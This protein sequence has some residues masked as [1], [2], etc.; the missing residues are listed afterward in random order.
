MEK[1]FLHFS[2]NLSFTAALEVTEEF[3]IAD[4]G[5]LSSLGQ[6]FLQSLGHLLTSLPRLR[7]LSC[8]QD[9]DI[10]SS[11]CWIRGGL[12]ESFSVKSSSLLNVNNLHAVAEPH[13][14]VSLGQPDQTLQLETEMSK[15]N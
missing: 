7:A 14:G 1:Q 6:Q 9:G 15:P 8:G 4:C 3:V 11:C 13:P 5:G 12:F 10:N 2:C